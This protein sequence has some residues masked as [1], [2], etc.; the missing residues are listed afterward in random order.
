MVQRAPPPPV[1]KKAEGQYPEVTNHTEQIQKKVYGD[2]GSYQ[3][4]IEN[5]SPA[6]AHLQQVNRTVLEQKIRIEAH[7][8][9]MVKEAEERKKKM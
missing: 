2:R 9:H 7:R 5:Q 8:E 4:V 6:T 1:A 3:A